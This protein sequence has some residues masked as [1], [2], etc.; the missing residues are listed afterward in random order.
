MER[1]LASLEDL[2]WSELKKLGE[3]LEC[4]RLYTSS[5]IFKERL[6]MV[7]QVKADNE[8]I[9]T[10]WDGLDKSDSDFAL[11]AS[12]RNSTYARFDSPSPETKEELLLATEYPKDDNSGL[13][14]L[15]IFRGDRPTQTAINSSRSERRTLVL[16]E[17]WDNEPSDEDSPL[18]KLEKPIEIPDSPL[19]PK[20]P[21]ENGSHLFFKEPAIE[22]SDDS[23]LFK[24]VRAARVDSESSSE[25]RTVQGP[26][27]KNW[28]LFDSPPTTSLELDLEVHKVTSPKHYGK[29][30]SISGRPTNNRSK[31]WK[32]IASLKPQPKYD[33]SQSFTVALSCCPGRRPRRKNI[34][35]P[36]FK[37]VPVNEEKEKP[38]LD[39]FE[40]LKEIGRGAFAKVYQVQHVKT[41]SIYAMKVLKKK[42]V[43]KKHQIEHIKTER[44]VLQLSQHP[45]CVTL[46]F[47]FQTPKKLY[48]VMDFYKGG[49][50]YFHL[51]KNR[52]FSEKIVRLMIA[53]ISLALGYLHTHGIIFRDLKPENVLIDEDGHLALT[54]FGLTKHLRKGE[55]TRTFCG[56][57]EYVAPEM[58]KECG[59]DKNVDWWSTGILCYELVIGAPPFYAQSINQ[60]YHKIQ[61]GKLSWKKSQV[62]LSEEIM[63][64]VSLLLDRN[65]FTRLGNGEGDVNQVLSHPF[66]DGLD[67]DDVM[68]KRIKP[69]YQPSFKYGRKNDNDTSNFVTNSV[70]DSPMIT[71]SFDFDRA[72]HFS[73]FSYGG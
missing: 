64:L 65:P 62:Q 60:M 66:F 6:L 34:K 17:L 9:S 24:A 48:L 11:P 57:P 54:D 70:V 20:R 30:P 38:C 3:R 44:Q 26:P 51:R 52:R 72:I 14:M 13:E 47:A 50:L 5:P 16:G 7:I 12:A 1:H 27:K 28:D 29:D 55:I 18:F 37:P 67:I 21:S 33:D 19:F 59:H 40:L 4:P 71:K 58:I 39:D 45:F 23:P 43:E 42:L 32:T 68:Q 53:E 41:R 35:I 36:T 2:D 31:L 61:H 15:D 56:T 10:A 8:S 49:E 46:R 69:E 73:G 63:S 25:I 22:A